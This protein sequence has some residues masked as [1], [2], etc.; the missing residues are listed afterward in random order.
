[1]SSIPNKLS[2]LIQLLALWSSFALVFVLG[3][4]ALTNFHFLDLVILRMLIA[5]FVLGVA[6]LWGRQISLSGGNRPNWPEVVLLGAVAITQVLIPFTFEYWA[7][8]G[9]SAVSVALIYSFSPVVTATIAVVL[10]Q[11]KLSSTKMAGLLIGLCGVFWGLLPQINGWDSFVFRIGFRECVVLGAVAS[12][13]LSWIFVEKLLKRGFSAFG[14][15]SVAMLL[16]GILCLAARIAFWGGDIEGF[17]YLFDLR[18]AS[19]VGFGSILVLSNFIG[20]PLYTELL[21]TH[22]P[23]FLSLTGFL[24][25]VLTLLFGYFIL[26]ETFFWGQFL[27]ALGLGWLSLHLYRK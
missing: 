12:S 22:S 26:N 17:G 25:P 14:I 24:C 10:G 11:E 19:W 3:K 1:M 13:S 16:G 21:R 23:T 6:G 5:G 20:Y 9:L 4:A 15:N 18:A 7:Q 8:R 2:S 27:L